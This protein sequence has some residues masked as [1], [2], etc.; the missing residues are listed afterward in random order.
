VPST[1]VDVTSRL[2]K[3][4]RSGALGVDRLRELVPDLMDAS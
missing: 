4:L 2:P 3:V 1:I